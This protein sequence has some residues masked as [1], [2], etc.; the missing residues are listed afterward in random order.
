MRARHL[1]RFRATRPAPVAAAVSNARE[2]G[3]AGRHSST[4]DAGRLELIDCLTSIRHETPRSI[5]SPLSSLKPPCAGRQQQSAWVSSA[6]RREAATLTFDERGAATQQAA[7]DCVI[8]KQVWIASI[9]TSS[10]GGTGGDW[11]QT[12]A[13]S[14]GP[15]VRPC[16]WREGP[17]V[18]AVD[19]SRHPLP[20]AR[21]RSQSSTRQ[22]RAC[23]PSRR[24]AFALHEC[25]PVVSARSSAHCFSGLGPLLICVSLSCTNQ[26][27]SY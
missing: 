4:D 12:R 2:I 13:R 5:P 15:M 24:P 25:G 1:W 3:E 20:K 27:P 23:S 16:C 8:Q 17:R 7:C 14:M 6:L 22:H 26:I 18:V 21:S 19:A 11:L 10:A 9:A